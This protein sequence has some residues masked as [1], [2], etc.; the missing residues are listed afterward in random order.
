MIQRD[1]DL[2]TSERVSLEETH[3]WPTI[4]IQQH[5][6]SMAN[7]DIHGSCFTYIPL[8]AEFSQFLKQ[9]TN[10]LGHTGAA[11]S[12]QHVER[13]DEAASRR[14]ARMWRMSILAMT[15]ADYGYNKIPVRN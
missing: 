3:R 13:L 5:H 12:A 2:G 1:G 11:T 7:G 8:E 6:R 14:M 15:P 4:A 9:G 10:N